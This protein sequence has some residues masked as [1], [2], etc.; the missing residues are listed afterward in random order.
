VRSAFA[1]ASAR[2]A[3]CSV[4]CEA[5]ERNRLAGTSFHVEGGVL[6][7]RRRWRTLAVDDHFE[8]YRLIKRVCAFSISTLP[9]SL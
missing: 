9:L 7:I 5:G 6:V 1:T 4:A 2:E 3:R 8:S